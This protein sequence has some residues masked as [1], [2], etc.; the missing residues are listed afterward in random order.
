GDGSKR[1]IQAAAAGPSIADQLRS[2]MDSASFRS[3]FSGRVS[4][5]SAAALASFLD[6][7]DM[8]AANAADCTFES[9]D[10]ASCFRAA[11]GSLS[12]QRDQA[13]LSRSARTS[14]G[15]PAAKSAALP[16]SFTRSSAA[17]R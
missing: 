8:T 15:A 5:Y 7:R 11:C 14:A 9:D 2:D 17:T 16:N 4:A 13:A 1:V 6:Q 3:L 10:A 12:A